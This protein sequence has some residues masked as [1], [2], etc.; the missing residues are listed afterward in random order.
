MRYLLLLC[1]FLLSSVL[2]IQPNPIVLK[3]GEQHIKLT[4]HLS[5]YLDH[6]SK[7][8]QHN[9]RT[10]NI[11]F[12]QSTKEQIS[13]GH[14][15][16][17]SLWVTFALQN[18]SEKPLEYLLE[19]SSP[20]VE[21]FNLY[22]PN[23]E[24]L[25]SSTGIHDLD[26]FK[27]N[28]GHT[29]TITVP[30]H[31][32]VTY[33][34]KVENHLSSLLL[35]ISLWDSDAYMESKNRY[36]NIVSLFAG[37]MLILIL[38]NMMLFFYTRDKS[39]IYYVLLTF[40]ML[41]HEIVS[42][43]YIL[44][45][46]KTILPTTTNAIHIMVLFTFI[47][48]PMFARSFLQLKEVMPLT[49]RYLKYMPIALIVITILSVYE[50]IPTSLNR[51]FFIMMITSVI[52]I[53]FIALFKGIKQAR[54]YAFGWTVV[55]MAFVSMALHRSGFLAFDPESIHLT[56]LSLVFEA[57]IFSVGLAA[58]IRY[59]KEEKE[60]SDAKLIS[61]QRQEKERLKNEVAL[62]TKELT[63]A[64][65]IK[66]L[67]L[68]EV[69][70]RVKNN[71]QIIISLLRLQSDQFD[72][73][74]LEEAM[75]V[76][77]QRIKAMGSVHEMLY[78]HDDIS[79][80]NTKEYFRS[81]ADE[82]RSAYDMSGN[83]IVTI[84]TDVSLDMERAIYTGLIINELVTNAYKYA[85]DAKGGEIH[86]SLKLDNGEYILQIS[87]N[88]KGGDLTG[89]DTSLGMT[90]VKTLVIHQLKGTIDSATEKGVRHTIRFKDKS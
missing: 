89:S 33:Y 73:K 18:S 78:A 86:I 90:L 64:L 77:E 74:R 59:V 71:M 4:P 1:F 34:M 30:A 54:Y 56:Q 48:V 44:L 47:F 83:V 37:A 3:G 40:A 25:D 66:N 68:K 76:T 87:D 35:N 28:I 53:A 49:D 39:Y 79:E 85:F 84:E 63:E 41:Y 43:G 46:S 14:Q 7:L 75:S 23:V 9:I 42:S 16:N 20:I 67:L 26:K 61:H 19:Y 6:T 60:A 45:F 81:L 52:F 58:R 62:R 65:S 2:A 57:L 15:Y 50:V 82:A 24:L 10:E 31:T 21:H 72:D 70:H 12:E 29:L 55:L 17:A 51:M 88:G 13:F 8:N 38:Y 36:W 11:P 5:Y 69:H 27:K 80:I 22:G 32:A